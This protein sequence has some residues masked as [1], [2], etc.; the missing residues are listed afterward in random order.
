MIDLSEI[1]AVLYESVIKKETPK[2]SAELIIECA[3]SF[4][5]GHISW[6]PSAPLNLSLFCS[7]NNFQKSVRVVFNEIR[8]TKTCEKSNA[9]KLHKALNVILANLLLAFFRPGR[10]SLRSPRSQYTY[11]KSNRYNPYD[12]GYRSAVSS[13]KG[14]EECGFVMKRP[15]THNLETGEQYQARIQMT[16]KLWELLVN[17]FSLGVENFVGLNF[18]ETIVLKN[19][20]KQVVDYEET[21]Q[22]I[23]MRKVLDRY[24][25]LL[26]KADIC[27]QD[28]GSSGEKKAPAARYFRVFNNGSF[29]QGGRFYGPWWQGISGDRRKSILINGNATVEL[30][31]SAMHLHLLY[32]FEGLNY[33]TVF[34]EHDDPYILPGYG[35]YERKVLK[36]GMLLALNAKTKASGNGAIRKKL[37]EESLWQKGLDLNGILERFSEKHSAIAHYL[38][39]SIGLKTQYEDACIAEYVIKKLTS[40]NVVCLC[41]HDSFIVEQAHEELLREMM[42]KGFKSR[43]LK[44]IPKIKVS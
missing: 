13:F 37:K 29:E 32:G 28:S 24:N 8:S 15:G 25:R 6:E 5:A 9:L 2:L 17:D 23:K 20:K 12:V 30:D 27:M 22:T 26:S 10:W 43:N 1:S 42:I 35:E 41:I 7:D 38:Y 44:S 18:G 3:A 19:E 11:R 40:R 14:L 33:Y 39:S 31:Y 36:Y 16:A 34:P 4:E 21:A